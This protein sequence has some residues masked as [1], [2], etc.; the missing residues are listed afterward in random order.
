MVPPRLQGA[1]CRERREHAVMAA[2]P[3][4]EGMEEKLHKP[5]GA[6]D[7]RAPAGHSGAANWSGRNEHKIPGGR[8]GVSNFG[9]VGGNSGTSGQAGGAELQCSKGSEQW[10]RNGRG[11]AVAARLPAWQGKVGSGSRGFSR[12]APKQ[13]VKNPSFN[14]VGC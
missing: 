1:L 7:P 9:A 13:M 10:Q 6:A 3:S 4:W 12:E 2:W 5:P 11:R 14:E 8:R